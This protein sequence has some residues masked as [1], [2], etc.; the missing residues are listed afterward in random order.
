[1]AV[2]LISGGT[3]LIGTKLTEHLTAAGYEVI[4]LSR[5]DDKVSANPA[6]SYSAWNVKKQVIDAAVVKKADHIIHLAG[7]GVMDKSWTPQYRQEIIDSRVH[8][9]E[10]LIKTIQEND[11]KIKT[12]VSASAIGWYGPDSDPVL[13]KEGF[14]EDDVAAKDFL[15]ETCLL[16]ESATYPVTGMGIRLVRLRT[17]IVLSNEGGAYKEFKKSLS[18]GFAGIFGNGRQLMSWIHI[19]DLCRMY[20]EALENN[21]LNGSY[22]AVAPVP[23]SNKKLVIG[24]AEQIRHKF[25]IPIHV[26]TLFLKLF[27]GERSIEILKSATVSCKKIKATGFTFLYPTIQAA[28]AELAGAK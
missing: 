24:M 13:H 25:Y 14:V 19:D 26:P 2:V 23:V 16:W 22:N 18:F 28:V 17:G 11:H 21:I 12:F 1:M 5:N 15:G 6:I 20:I 4:L 7:A 10:L 27:M 9:A 8:S 3:G